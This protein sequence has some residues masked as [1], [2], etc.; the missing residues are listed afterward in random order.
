MSILEQ[1]LAELKALDKEAR[2]LEHVSATMSWDQET[3]MPPRAVDERAEQVALL[4][5]LIHERITSPRVGELLA[6]AGA[7]PTSDEIEVSVDGLGEIDNA[8]LR[9]KRRQYRLAT[10]LPTRLVREL[11]ETGSRGQN[12]W[13]GARK[14][15][16][17]ETFKPWLAKLIALNRETADA[18]G[19]EA[20]RYDALL[21]QYEP[22]ARTA[23]V[24]DVFG[25]VRAGLV[26]LV[27]KIGAV[28]QVD[29]SFFN[30]RFAEEQQDEFGRMVMTSLGYDTSRGRLDKS[31]HPFTT[32][33]GGDDIRIT[34]RYD[35]SLVAS[36]LFSTIHETGHALYELGVD[37]ALHGTLLAE[38][39]SLG[40]HESQSRMWENMIGR[41]R[42]FWNHWLPTVR[43]LFPAQLSSVG[44]DDFY[45]AVNKV[46]PSFIRV[47][48][49]EVTYGL[50][51]ILRFELEQA[52]ID[53]D[54]SVD[55][56]PGAWNEKMHELL[57]ITPPTDAQGVLQD[58]HW[59]FGA[60]GYFPTYALGN[61]YAAQF[62]SRMERE[63]PDLWKQVAS[64]ETRPILDWLGEHIHRHG[65]ARSAGRLI[66]DVCGGDL[67]PRFFLD[68]LNEKY[69][70]L[71]GL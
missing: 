37:P 59:S 34:T 2:L 24:A 11:A 53:D 27:E 64:G 62:F 22:Y 25:R 10:R 68:Y 15:D 57:G 40:I 56:L 1:T 39:T 9:E 48:A 28:R 5:G 47:E 30:A 4:Q 67:D 29:D 52:L 46:E 69:G 21:D 42:H 23:E 70:A 61:L 38:G 16:D 41:S 51:I 14:A 60:F 36:G 3:Y 45:R 54:L 12:A 33:L 50:H 66:R 43:K 32:M 26:D 55:D 65:K 63:I 31:A 58:V 35:E 13:A 18:L 49:D 20:C 7:D 19:Y 17:Y 6:A 44:L 71:Y 8:F